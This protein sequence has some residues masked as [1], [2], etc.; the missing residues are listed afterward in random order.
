MEI[1]RDMLYEVDYMGAYHKTDGDEHA[2]VRSHLTKLLRPSGY[3]PDCLQNFFAPLMLSVMHQGNVRGLPPYQDER[4]RRDNS[5]DMKVKIRGFRLTC[6]TDESNRQFLNIHKT[7]I[8]S[9]VD[10]IHGVKLYY[11]SHLDLVQASFHK[12]DKS[13]FFTKLKSFFD[14]L[15]ELSVPVDFIEERLVYRTHGSKA[16]VKVWRDDLM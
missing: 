12:N 10:F 15:E 13:S 1:V 16:L 14:L 3:P 11:R 4:I 9:Y 2:Y 5:L 7:P 8:R 6:Y